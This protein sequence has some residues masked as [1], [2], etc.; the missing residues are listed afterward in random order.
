MASTLDGGHGDDATRGSGL[1]FAELGR[2][3]GIFNNEIY[4][5]VVIVIALTILLPP[6]VMKCYF[7]RY[8]QIVAW[9]ARRLKVMCLRL[10]SR[11]INQA[12][13]GQ[14]STAACPCAALLIQQ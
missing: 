12:R 9:W 13:A 10:S 11:I 7:G 5:G 3:S 4:A 2:V 14:W 6:F 8:G 1:D